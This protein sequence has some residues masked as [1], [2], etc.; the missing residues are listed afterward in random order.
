MTA[1][2]GF[3]NGILGAI[4]S[5]FDYFRE[6]RIIDAIE[7]KYK[8]EAEYEIEK[9]RREAAELILENEKKLREISEKVE[10]ICAPEVDKTSRTIEG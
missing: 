9:Q 8:A 2:L 7:D 5:V 4:S 10:E 6:K 1:I 3:V